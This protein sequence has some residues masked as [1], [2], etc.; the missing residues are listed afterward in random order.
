MVYIMDHSGV[1]Y[2]DSRDM[3]EG[4]ISSAMICT[5]NSEILFDVKQKVPIWLIV[6]GVS[7]IH[8]VVEDS[9]CVQGI[10]VCMLCS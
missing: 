3:G 5:R 7:N 6:G 4:R 9:H 8:H 1:L 10:G 2:N